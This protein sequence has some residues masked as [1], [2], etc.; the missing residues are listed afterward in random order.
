MLGPSRTMGATA[1]QPW[2]SNGRWPGLF[3]VMVSLFLATGH[4]T[5]GERCALSPVMPSAFQSRA[6]GPLEGRRANA[7]A[8]SAA[9]AVGSFEAYIVVPHARARLV[10]PRAWSGRCGR[11]ARRSG[12]FSAV[13]AAEAAQGDESA[14]DA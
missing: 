3:V 8:P 2:L 5:G 10:P 4:G 7:H 14:G 1:R 13:V 11:E 9:Q 6:R 12:L